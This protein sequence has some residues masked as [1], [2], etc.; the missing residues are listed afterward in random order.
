MGSRSETQQGYL[1]VLDFLVTGIKEH[2]FEPGGRIPTE[3]ELAEQFRVSRAVTRRAL[4]ELDAQ[5]L[6]RRQVGRG[7]VVRPPDTKAPEP[8]PIA[9]IDG[10]ISPSQYIESRLRFEPQ[11]AWLVATNANAM[12]F[13]RM[14]DCLK[15]IDA[16]TSRDEFELWD[17]AFHLAIAAA[18]HNVVA[19]R[20]YDMIHAVRHDQA[21]WRTVK[22]RRQTAEERLEFQHEHHEIFDALNGRNPERACGLMAQH[23]RAT[24]RRLLDF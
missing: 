11:F 14:A 15:R 21:M 5:G 23:I 17:A 2:A 22:Q 1:R 3:R 13:E 12:D 7:T 19:I 18:T 4:A 8:L 9:T 6:I 24:R 10:S 20:M 16:A